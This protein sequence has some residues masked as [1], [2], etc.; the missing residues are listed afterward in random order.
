MQTQIT[1]TV[2]KKGVDLI[3]RIPRKHRDKFKRGD[4]VV[5]I[6]TPPLRFVPASQLSKR[7]KS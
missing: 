5:V 7:D 2:S 6:K 4:D 1:S 3:V